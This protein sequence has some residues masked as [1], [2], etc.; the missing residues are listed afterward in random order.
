SL[1]ADSILEFPARRGSD[2][3]DRQRGLV[4][5]AGSGVAAYA[6]SPSPSPVP[7]AGALHWLNVRGQTRLRATYTLPDRH[8]P[9]EL[10][11]RRA[12]SDHSGP[13]WRGLLLE[14]RHTFCA[15]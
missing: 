7:S 3:A 11:P 8:Q 12:L 15:I 14:A 2:R 6:G 9:K 1:R 4:S 10:A 13:W 5:P